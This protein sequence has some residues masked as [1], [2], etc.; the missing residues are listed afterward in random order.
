M[1]GSGSGLTLRLR[2]VVDTGWHLRDRRYEEAHAI[3]AQGGDD[4]LVVTSLGGAPQHPSWYLNL[5]V[6]AEPEIQLRAEHSPP[7]RAPPPT[8]KLAALADRHRTD[9]RTTRV[10]D[11]HRSRD[12]ARGVVASMTADAVPWAERID[13]SSDSV[14]GGERRV[15]A[16]RGSA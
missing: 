1:C 6:N 3:F 14:K 13:D 16:G 9:G 8:T 15:D 5:N 12:P 2:Y 7:P 11:A 4:H 10:P